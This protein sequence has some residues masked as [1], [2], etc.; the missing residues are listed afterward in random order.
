M[1]HWCDTWPHDIYASVLLKDNKIKLWKVGQNKLS[2]SYNT[3]ALAEQHPEYSYKEICFT[4]NNN[5][6]HNNAFDVLSREWFKQWEVHEDFRGINPHDPP[7]FKPGD[8]LI[9]TRFEIVKPLKEGN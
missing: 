5:D 7:E 2:D 6:E 3:S 1:A 9:G 8:V 4:V